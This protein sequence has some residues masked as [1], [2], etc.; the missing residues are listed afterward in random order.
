MPTLWTVSVTEGANVAFP[1]W[2]KLESHHFY[3]T[4]IIHC[5]STTLILGLWL[6]LSGFYHSP[7][8]FLN[9]YCAY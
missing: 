5:H 9:T 2:E 8:L 3:Q 7:I 1:A 6:H 4:F